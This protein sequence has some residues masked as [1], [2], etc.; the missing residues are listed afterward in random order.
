MKI[1]DNLSAEN[2]L[3]FY[4]NPN[5]PPELDTAVY[6]TFLPTFKENTSLMKYFFHGFNITRRQNNFLAMQNKFLVN[7]INQLNQLLSLC[8]NENRNLNNLLDEVTRTKENIRKPFESLC[9]ASYE[10]IESLAHV[11]PRNVYDGLIDR[12]FAAT[13]KKIRAKEKIKVAFVT[14]NAAMWC[15]NDLYNMFAEN[16]RYDVKVY[17]SVDF[18]KGNSPSVKRDWQR[19]VEQFKTRG[20]NVT[21]LDSL[22]AQIDKQDVII[23]LNPYLET[24]PYSLRLAALTAET[25]L[26]NIPYAFD[27]TGLDIYNLPLFHVIWKHFFD[28]KSHMMTQEKNSKV[29]V[30]G[31][32]SGYPRHGEKIF[33]PVEDDT[34]RRREN[35]IRAALVD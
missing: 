4:G 34:S 19:G 20:I 3:P 6:Q 16:S 24:F 13:V 25:L 28:T 27:S 1:F 22:N 32:Y 10:Y 17:L 31:C 18:S 9:G 23:F 12:I 21:G 11:L 33:V 29:A 5:I 15:G 7:R 26:V 35:N 8:L 2:I 14:Y 30:H